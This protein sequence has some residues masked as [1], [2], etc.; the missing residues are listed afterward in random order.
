[1]NKLSTIQKR[2]NLNVDTFAVTAKRRERVK[3]EFRNK[4]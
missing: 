4:A 1:M 2:E 3:I